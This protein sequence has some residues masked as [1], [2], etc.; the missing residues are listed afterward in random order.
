M[1][2]G[3]CFV[4]IHDPDDGFGGGAGAR[5]G[6]TLPRDDEYSVPEGWIGGHTKIGPVLEV[7]VTYHLDRHGI[8]VQVKSLKDDG[9]LSWIVISRGTNKYMEEMYEEKG[10]SFYDKRWQ[11]APARETRRDKTQGT[12]KSTIISCLQSV[13]TK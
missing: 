7:R 2:P 6:Y 13:H 5:R 10:E 1:S 11:L 9:F 3:P 4:T 8:E 12:T